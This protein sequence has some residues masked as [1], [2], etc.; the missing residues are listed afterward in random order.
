[1]LILSR[2]RD[3][4]VIIGKEIIIKV[5]GIYGSQVR[6]GFLAPREVEILRDEHFSEQDFSKLCQSISSKNEIN[7]SWVFKHFS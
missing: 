7:R 5:L 4:H 2:S 1:M 6:L 3:E